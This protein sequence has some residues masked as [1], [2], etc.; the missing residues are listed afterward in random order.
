[1]RML[2]VIVALL[3][4]GEIARPALAEDATGLLASIVAGDV[5]RVERALAIGADP[6][7]SLG[8]GTTPLMLA[9]AFSPEPRVLEVLVRAGADPLAEDASG[10]SPLSHAARRGNL[11]AVR[12]LLDREFAASLVNRRDRF[13]DGPID[14]AVLTGSGPIA[15]LLLEAGA[16][17]YTRGLG[18]QPAREACRRQRSNPACTFIVR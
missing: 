4:G 9:A 12:W 18:R 5:A 16:D 3:F 8:R 7:R 2:L 15:R 6:N 17:P 14:E 10:L 1:M 13:G 11:E